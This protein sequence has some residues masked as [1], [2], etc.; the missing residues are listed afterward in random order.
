MASERAR[1]RQVQ[2]RRRLLAALV[3]LGPGLLIFAEDVLRRAAHLGTFDDIHRT[4]W[5]ASVAG[6]IV[7]WAVL[8]Y[9]SA[10][11]RGVAAQ[12]AAG[13]FATLYALATGVQASF[14]ALY[15]CY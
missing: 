2:K 14:F 8:L 1:R 13:V 12:A 11:R 7:F 6:S 3:I 9:A 4:G 10:S 5:I 15:N